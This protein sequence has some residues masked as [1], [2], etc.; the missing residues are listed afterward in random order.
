MTDFNAQQEV[1]RLGKLAGRKV[2]LIGCDRQDCTWRVIVTA[3]IS[4]RDAVRV[5]VALGG[6]A[7][8][9]ENKAVISRC[10]EHRD[11][12]GDQPALAEASAS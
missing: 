1:D 4:P 10:S 2:S 9:D 6:T 7:H 12:S 8:I 3:D 5:V 11:P